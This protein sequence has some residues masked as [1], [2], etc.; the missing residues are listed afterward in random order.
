[1]P[2]ASGAL[3]SA[4]EHYLDTVGVAGSKPAGPT[5]GNAT[6]DA[7]SVKSGALFR[8]VRTFMETEAEMEDLWW[9]V[10]QASA[11]QHVGLGVILGRLARESQER[12]K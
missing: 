6:G 8:M 1:M 3:S 4:V 7:N 10:E 2:R 9:K 5:P 11:E 12:R